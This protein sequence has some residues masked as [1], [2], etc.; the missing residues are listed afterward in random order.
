MTGWPTP[1]TAVARIRYPG[2]ALVDSARREQRVDGWGGL[3]AALCAEDS[4]VIRIQAL[5]RLVPESGA[6]LRGWHDDHLVPGAPALARN[7]AAQAA[8]ATCSP[9]SAARRPSPRS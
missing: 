7:V 4:P 9:T 1:N 2:I 6:A 5:Q 3:L 8:P